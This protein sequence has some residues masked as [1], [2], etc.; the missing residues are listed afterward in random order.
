MVKVLVMD[1]E[2]SLRDILSNTLKS[3]GHT[4]ITS[5][6]GRQAVEISKQENPDLALLDIQV[7]DMDGL[8]VLKELKNINPNIRG[9]ML[10][11][12]ADVE[13][14]VSAIKK[15]ASDFISKPFKIDDVKNIVNKVLQ[16]KTGPAGVPGVITGVP[17]PSAASGIKK[18][19]KVKRKFAINKA[20]AMKV[21]VA[22]AIL[23]LAGTILKMSLTKK[24][25]F[26]QYSIPY[27]NPAGMCWIKPNLWV[28]DWVTGNIYKH[29]TEGTFSILT[30]YKTPNAQ[31]I[32]LAFDGENIWTCNSIEQRIYRHKIDESLTVEAIYSNPNSNPTGLYFDGVNLWILDSN[33]AKIYK[34]RM[35]DTLSVTAVYDSPAINPC[36]MFRDGEYFYIGDYKTARIYKVSVKDFSVSDVY[37]IPHFVD[38]NYRLSS[39]TWDGKNIWAAADELGK[40]FSI[41]IN[42]LKP[43]RF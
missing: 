24:S 43:I 42:T 23:I 25:V 35:D 16:L 40:V 26:H 22:L 4:V 13:M 12:S 31:P 39:I 20:L 33:T 15:G 11:G 17:T 19:K 5:E 8:E 32:G 34:H 9:I 3:M 29:T 10:S 6:D 27:T 28:S 37:T 30:V 7:P 18:I 21:S 2:P 38:M 1:D 14:A 36:G 41:S